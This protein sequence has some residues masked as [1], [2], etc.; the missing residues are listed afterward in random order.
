MKSL[1]SRHNAKKTVMVNG[2]V[3]SHIVKDAHPASMLLGRGFI[4]HFV[5]HV[6]DG[7]MLLLLVIVDD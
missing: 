4:N 2:A 7:L 5:A 1:L 3:I 6:H